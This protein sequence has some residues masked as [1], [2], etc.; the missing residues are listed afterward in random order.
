[1]HFNSD[2]KEGT[3]KATSTCI[4]AKT[5]T[6]TSAG[7][8]GRDCIKLVDVYGDGDAKLVV[9]DA[10]KRLKM[11]KGSTLFGEQAILGVPSAL[12]YFYSDT[13]RPR[14]PALAVAS[15]SFVYI[16]RHFRPHYKF[17]VPTIEID[18]EELK[19]W[20]AL[21]KCALEI[22]AA[23]AQ[24]TSMRGL[25]IR[26]SERSRGLLAID[27]IDEQAEYVT[28]FMDEPLVERACV[29]CM[30]SVNKNMDESDAPRGR[31]RSHDGVRARPA[32]YVDRPADQGPG[33]PGRA[34][35]LRALRRRVPLDRHDAQRLG[36]H[37][38]ERR[39]PEERD[40][41][42]V[43]AVRAAAAR[44]E[45]CGRVHEPEA[46][47]VPPQ[48]E[49]E[50]E[51][52]DAGRHCRDRGVQPPAHEGHARR[53]RGAQERRHH[54]VQREGQ[55]VH[56]QHG[57]A[58]HGAG[59]RSVRAGGSVARAALEERHPAQHSKEDQ[60]VRGAD[61]ARARPRDRDAPPLPTRP[62]QAAPHDRARVRQDHPGRAG[63]GVVHH[64]RCDPLERA[65][66]GHRAVVPHQ[67]ERPER[68][69][70]VRVR[71][72]VHLGDWRGGQR[73]HLRLRQ[74]EVR[75]AWRLE[76]LD[77]ELDGCLIAVV[78]PSSCVPLVSAVVTMPLS[79]PEL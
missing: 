13:S 27:D 72:R 45:H 39:A 22:S 7:D 8:G 15:G 74:G 69:V 32:G 78:A 62:L 75:D 10:D 67:A 38:Q 12:S 31:D 19:V 33:C 73:L 35:G 59:V 40:R 36:V 24:L 65:G 56:A 63:A 26:L 76:D 54:A 42:R 28:R 57:L 43:A 79:E 3:R 68:A 55:G 23:L 6:K 9:A 49:E 51:P 50:L 53:A 66:A 71:R 5:T 21:A 60:A 2:I 34:R 61:A 52:D 20:E 77:T 47:V 30:T 16:Y 14:I 4:P 17:T 70:H 18:V 64:R 11:F 58:H 29:T 48:G 1:M 46:R 37:D 41:A 25:G 44:A